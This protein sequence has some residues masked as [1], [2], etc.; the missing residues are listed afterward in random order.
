MLITEQ[1]DLRTMGWVPQRGN[2][3]PSI[4]GRLTGGRREIKALTDAV[5]EKKRF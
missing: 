3:G 5:L 2:V 1:A 4:T